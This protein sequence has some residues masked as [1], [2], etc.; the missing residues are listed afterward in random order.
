MSV[1]LCVSIYRSVAVLL[2][3]ATSTFLF[4]AACEIIVG[5][6][7]PFGPANQVYESTN[8]GLRWMVAGVQVT[9]Q[10]F[11]VGQE[12]RATTVRSKLHNTHRAMPVP[13]RSTT[14]TFTTLANRL[15]PSDAECGCPHKTGAHRKQAPCTRARARARA[16]QRSRKNQPTAKAGPPY[17]VTSVVH[18]PRQ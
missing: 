13:Q 8:R 2:W 3:S 10:S 12:T 9:A 4:V 6:L 15:L 11:K 1:Y 18:K 16:R 5:G 7:C 14:S 17:Y